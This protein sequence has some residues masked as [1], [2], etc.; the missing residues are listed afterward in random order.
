MIRFLKNLTT[1]NILLEDLRADNIIVEPNLLNGG[2]RRIFVDLSS[3]DPLSQQDLDDGCGCIDLEGEGLQL[4]AMH[5]SI[6]VD[7]QPAPPSSPFPERMGFTLRQQ[8]TLKTGRLL[9]TANSNWTLCWQLIMHDIFRFSDQRAELEKMEFTIEIARVQG[10]HESS[11]AT[12]TTKSMAFAAGRTLHMLFGRPHIA[13][14]S[15]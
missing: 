1:L 3:L 12:D 7:L 13:Y 4:I 5:T 14:N 10:N 6:P 8:H 2:S 11:N 15:L 9:F